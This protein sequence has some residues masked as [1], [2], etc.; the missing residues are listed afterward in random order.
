LIKN[1]GAAVLITPDYG[2]TMVFFVLALALTFLAAAFS[3]V[4]P[5]VPPGTECR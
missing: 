1:A 4:Q 3:D 5:V 2:Q